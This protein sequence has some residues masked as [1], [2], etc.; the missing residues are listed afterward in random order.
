[1]STEV[2]AAQFSLRSISAPGAAQVDQMSTSE[3]RAGFLL[4]RLFEPGEIRLVYTDLDRLI[5]GGILPLAPLRLP[6]FPELGTAFFAER[7]E[8]GILNLGAA[9]TVTVDG[10]TFDLDRY[11]S[12]YVG[13]G[14][15]DLVFE[16]STDEPAAFYFTSAPAHRPCPTT[17]V[18]RA[19]AV[20]V[21]LG[22]DAHSCRRRIVKSICPDTVESCQL[23]L[24]F[25]ELMPNSVWNTM[26]PHTHSRR[27]EIY[28]YFDLD[29]EMVFHLMGSPGNTRHL[30]VRNREAVLSPSW[31]LHS[32]AGTTNYRFAWVMAGENQNFGDIDPLPLSH[33]R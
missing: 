5:V 25:T 33:L 12:L 19:Q 16:S 24:G 29:G 17:R 1:M 6:V 18:Q 10:E 13:M 8:V 2:Q 11:D 14:A 28:L 7:R 3:L 4:E 32:G 27:S 15:E 31:S 9:G 23:V 26:P 20:E 21:A 30:V 22:D